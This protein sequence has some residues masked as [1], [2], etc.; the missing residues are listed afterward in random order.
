VSDQDERDD[1]EEVG[2]EASPLIAGD[3]VGQLTLVQVVGKGPRSALWECTCSCG[4]VTI[5]PGHALKH[6]KK[7]GQQ[8]MCRDCI[9]KARVARSRKWHEDRRHWLKIEMFRRTWEATGS[10]Y[11]DRYIEMMTH[12]IREDLDLPTPIE[13]LPADP[14]AEED[15]ECASK[16][17]IYPDWE[18][19]M[20]LE[21]VGAVMGITRERVR[22]IEAIALN[23]LRRTM[24]AAEKD[25]SWRMTIDYHKRWSPIRGGLKF[26]TVEPLKL[27]TAEVKTANEEVTEIEM[28]PKW[29][30][31][32]LGVP[33][34]H[35]L[36]R[37]AAETLGW[38]VSLW[39]N[40][41]SRLEPA[42]TVMGWA[43]RPWGYYS[44]A[45]V[46][47][48]RAKWAGSSAR[49]GR[50][51][52]RASLGIPEGHMLSS[53]AAKSLGW[54]IHNWHNRT[55]G[56]K[57]MGY[58]KGWAGQQWAYY[59]AEQVEEVREKWKGK[60]PGSRRI[61]KDEKFRPTGRRVLKVGPPVDPDAFPALL[62]VKAKVSGIPM[63]IPVFVQ[64]MAK[65][66]DGNHQ[67][68]VT[69]AGSS[70]SILPSIIVWAKDLL[71]T[72]YSP[73]TTPW[74]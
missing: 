70:D 74:D 10:L 71:A 15:Y 1:F 59:S 40:R 39:N 69:F 21:E 37:E 73:F 12:E 31:E 34:G 4:N 18:P 44:T 67:V 5:R 7:Y 14:R 66:G 2:V 50:K 52:D 65:M 64:Q 35:M 54:R 56:W 11:S 48:V 47:E 16:F 9:R 26:K 53:E 36:A 3:V 43:G 45:Q 22:Q 68:R 42:G 6:S 49:P 17:P 33:E 24:N 19:E 13:G 8:S 57:P 55:V 41:T 58:V 32:D 72:D 61:H 60:P 38:S 23:K 28:N 63:T 27:K 25:G 20:T 62:V 30:R 46:E 51:V 29:K